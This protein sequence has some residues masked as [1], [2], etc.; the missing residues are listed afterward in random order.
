MRHWAITVT[1]LLCALRW[2]HPQAQTVWFD[3]LIGTTQSLNDAQGSALLE[4]IR[5][6]IYHPDE[7][8]EWPGFARID[9]QARILFL[10][11]SD[12]QRSADVF[13]GTGQGWSAAAQNALRKARSA[14]A[15]GRVVKLDV[16]TSA[17]AYRGMDIPKVI[18]GDRSRFGLALGTELGVAFVPEETVA[19]TL[20]NSRGKL[21]MS[22][23]EETQA[24]RFEAPLSL[25]DLRA[26]PALFTF[27]TDA[28]GA[29]S[30]PTQRLYRGHLLFSPERLDD[31]MLLDAA[32]AAGH[33]LRQ[34]VRPDGRFHYKYLPKQNTVPDDYNL[35]RHCGTVYA[36][37]DLCETTGDPALM[38]AAVRALDWMVD[39]IDIGPDGTAVLPDEQ[40]DIKVGGQGL[41]LVALAEHAE[42]TG[43]L[44]HLGTM[45]A[46]ARHLASLQQPDGRFSPHKQEAASGQAS[47]FVS[48]YY[49]GEAMLGLAR[50][51]A[52]DGNSE[53][54][55]VAMAN[56]RYITQ[57]RDRGRPSKDLP[58][59]HWLLYALHDLYRARPE[60]WLLEQTERYGR[61]IVGAQRNGAGDTPPDWAGSFY[62]PPR[63]TPSATRAE[64]LLAAAALLR[65]C[66]DPDVGAEFLLAAERATAFM[67]QLQFD[68]ISA[69][70]L[71]DPLRAQGGIRKSMTNYTVQI[72]YVQHGLSAMLALLRTPIDCRSA[73]RD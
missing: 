49:P 63:S 24:M 3:D 48:G 57:Q 8:P 60:P 5:S 58:H 15:S 23:V 54:I 41:A 39:H 36:M 4:A 43:D 22:N 31:N 10:S 7:M 28:W 32:T 19:R 16:V 67:L 27:T 42:R 51:H 73:G 35:L 37:L 1:V 6:G 50:L 20:V 45:Q 52:L 30:H 13:I 17:T 29:V 47:D 40:G 71:D 56:A 33:Y 25:A 11:A 55:D 53:W 2:G 72:D 66:G 68:P 44:R 46:L 12:G 62:T 9:T 38:E 21:Q 14:S 34:A 70:Y 59:D 26:T 18:D 65:E 61:A 69:M 64:G